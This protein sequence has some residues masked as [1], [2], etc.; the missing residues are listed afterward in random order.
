MTDA[1]Q[2]RHPDAKVTDVY[3]VDVTKGN[4]RR[5]RFRIRYGAGSG[6]EYVFM[7]AEGDFREL[8]AANGN[9]FNEPKLFSSGLELPVAH[10]K[11][12]KVLMD[13][14]SLDWLI[15][16][17]D[18]K[19]QGGTP[20]DC[21]A[22]LSASQAL[23]GVLG[24]ASVHGRYWGLTRTTPPELS[25]L[26]DWEPTDGFVQSLRRAVPAGLAN[27]SDVLPPF[28]L[29]MGA[30]TLV[31]HMVRA[32]RSFRQGPQTLLHGDAHVGNTYRLPGDQLGFLDWQVAR[33]GNASQ[34][35]GYFFVSALSVED[36]RLHEQDI[37]RE[38]LGALGLTDDRRPAMDD[39]WLRYRASIPFAL[40][41]WIATASTARTQTAKGS[42][43]LCHRYAEAFVDLKSLEALD[44]LGV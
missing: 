7:K 21:E 13:E 42:A 25:W 28:I 40:A 38:Y 41:V 22:T 33:R 29:R 6:P 23:N 4:N 12:Y 3:L 37:I 19:T 20:C 8:H 14:T 11:A 9:L 17:E 36:R 10:A 15:V 24:L 18:V 31:E 43:S 16:M 34:D 27:T 32:M 5:A 39:T 1:I 35:V 44:A 2:G 26:S 30:D